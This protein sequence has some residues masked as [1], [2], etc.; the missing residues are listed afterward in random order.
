MGKGIRDYNL[1]SRCAHSH[2][3]ALSLAFVW[4]EL[5]NICGYTNIHV[6]TSH[7]LTTYI[8]ITEIINIHTRTHRTKVYI[9]I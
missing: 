8:V 6:Q 3:G 2:C 7:I 9:G 1:G 4:T 5:G